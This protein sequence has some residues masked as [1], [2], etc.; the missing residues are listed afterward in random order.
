[1]KITTIVA[2]TVAISGFHSTCIIYQYQKLYFPFV[3]FESF[4]QKY[5]TRTINIQ[6]FETAEKNS[7]WVNDI[8]DQHKK[9][10]S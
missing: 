7:Y 10:S 8:T 4:I 2:L 5:K 1:M 3:K 6:K 9:I